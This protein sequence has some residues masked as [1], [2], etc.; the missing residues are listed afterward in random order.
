[1]PLSLKSS[2]VSTPALRTA[3]ASARAPPSPMLLPRSDS[4]LMALLA[5]KAL[6]MA[7][8]PR[9]ARQNSV[10]RKSVAQACGVRCQRKRNGCRGSVKQSEA[11]R[12][13]ERVRET[14][15]FRTQIA[16]KCV[17][18]VFTLHCGY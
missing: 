9:A 5:S 1:M 13:R 2:L 18:A 14:A 8:Q 17:P 10:K 15:P 4:S 3:A 16:T 11:N 12:A 7:A 6:A